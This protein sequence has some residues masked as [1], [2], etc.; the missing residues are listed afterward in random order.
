MLDTLGYPHAKACCGNLLQTTSEPFTILPICVL[1]AAPQRGRGHT[2]GQLRRAALL[3]AFRFA[4]QDWLWRQYKMLGQGRAKQLLGQH[5]DSN[6]STMPESIRREIS[7]NKWQSDWFFQAWFSKP[8]HTDHLEARH[9]VMHLLAEICA[10]DENV[11]SI[12]DLGCCSGTFLRDASLV[13]PRQVR[14]HGWEMSEE[15]VAALTQRYGKD[16]RFK[17][18]QT[19]DYTPLFEASEHS[20]LVTI[21]TLQYFSEAELREF[22]SRLSQRPHKVRLV[23][24]EISQFGL[25]DA[26]HS[27]LRANQTYNHDYKKMLTEFGFS[28]RNSDM[29]F[30][31]E[32]VNWVIISV[33]R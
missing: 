18:F 12:D 24:A 17:F 4:P 28:I 33:E 7:D 25:G 14:L 23:L 3:S 11:K 10:R 32:N 22:L 13:L 15:A 8:I 27:T 20:I 31:K 21:G 5:F 9:R 1:A 16:P 26:P 2:M 19:R 29:F 30:F 6:E